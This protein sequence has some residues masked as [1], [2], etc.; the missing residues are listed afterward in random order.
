MNPPLA[1]DTG[2][3]YGTPPT[4]TSSSGITYDSGTRSFQDNRKFDKSLAGTYQ[5]YVLL[6]DDGSIHTALF[7]V[8]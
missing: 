7:K 1:S 6:L 8:T 5:E 4:T 3:P 2:G